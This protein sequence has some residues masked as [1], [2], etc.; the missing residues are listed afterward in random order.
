MLLSQKLLFN[1]VSVFDVIENQKK[2]LGD[3]LHHLASFRL[4]DD[5]LPERLATEFGISV[6]V[7]DEEKKY[8]RKRPTEI[9]VS[10]NPMSAILYGHSGPHYVKGTELSIFVPFSGDPEVFEVRPASFDFNPPRGDVVG[11]E[12]CLTY[13]FVEN[14]NLDEYQRAITS[15]KKY[16]DWLRPSAAQLSK[17][18]EQQARNMIQE[19]KRQGMGQAKALEALGIPIIDEVPSSPGPGASAR[20]HVKTAG[21]TP[22]ANQTGWDVFI[23][24]ASEDKDDIARPL[25]NALEGAGVAVWYDEFSLR[26]GDSLRQSIDRGLSGSRYGAVI[27]S[28]HF[29]EKHWP[30]QEL[31]GLATREVGGRKVILPI[32]H[33][34]RFEDVR[35]YSPTLADRIAVSTVEGLDKVVQKIV[36]AIR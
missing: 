21:K 5:G 35:N 9:D 23:S 19:R 8:A 17:E 13:N 26:L 12:L 3:E 18:L 29:F 24:H 10:R 22:R 28:P 16:L 34:V 33:R 32:W 27:L 4:D 14:V 20:Q 6:P 36:E 2:R 15:V 1:S 25:A 30:Q 7:L 31:N 11:T